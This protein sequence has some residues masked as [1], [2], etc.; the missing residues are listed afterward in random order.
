M[1]LDALLNA[2]LVSASPTPLRTLGHGVGKPD[3]RI[4][5]VGECWGEE[6]ERH[7]RP[8]SGRSGIELGH[9]LH[10]AGIM[11]SEC[12]LTNVV[13]ARPPRNDIDAWAPTKKKDI[14][15]NMVE[16]RGR[17]VAPILFQGYQQLLKEIELV[18][19]SVIITL[20]NAAMFALCGR[21]GITK[22]RGSLLEYKGIRTIPTFNPA[23]V[24]RMWE[25]R[26]LAVL[27]LSRAARELGGR[28]AEPA[29]DFLTSPTYSQVLARLAALLNRAYDY[30]EELWLDFDIETVAGH[31]RCF[32][33]SWSRTEAI[34]IPLMAEGMPTGYWT[35]EQ[36]A[37]IMYLVRK[38]F[39]HPNVRLRGQNLLF[40]FQYVYRWWHFIPNL[41]QDSMLSHHVL[42]AGLPKSLLFQASM[43][44]EYFWDWKDLV[45]HNEAEEKEGA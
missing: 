1:D 29:W 33:I 19:P 34:C 20:G 45:R 43:Y 10:D 15:H 18:N 2:P 22:W 36:E 44:C 42:W 24:L 12:F 4:L 26:P 5:I 3:A 9:M 21:S 7:G 11:L 14:T 16:L 6:E 37:W 39:T 25:W 13:N 32:A 17:Y 35:P 38:L 41:G 23:A 28:A 8:F 27:D 40:D 31:I 30:E